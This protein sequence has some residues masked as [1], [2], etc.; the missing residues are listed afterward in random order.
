MQSK[1]MENQDIVK[2]TDFNSDPFA[3]KSKKQLLTSD[4]G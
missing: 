4:L 2:A 1:D 3:Y